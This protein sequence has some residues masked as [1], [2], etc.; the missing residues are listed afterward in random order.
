MATIVRTIQRIVRPASSG[1][2]AIC[3]AR[4]F[5]CTA[6]RSSRNP[7]GPY[8]S[9]LEWRGYPRPPEAFSLTLP[10]HL[11]ALAADAHTFHISEDC[12]DPK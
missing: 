2:A 5:A 9:F 7:Q 12:H 6:A 3:S 4:A 1:C 10:A 8:D 11:R